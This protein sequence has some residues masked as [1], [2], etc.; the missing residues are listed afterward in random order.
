MYSD[1]IWEIGMLLTVCVRAGSHQE[2]NRQ[3]DEYFVF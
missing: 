3:G 2:G 1:S